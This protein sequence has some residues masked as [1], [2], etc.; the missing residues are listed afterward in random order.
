[1]AAADVRAVVLLPD[2]ERKLVPSGADAADF[3]LSVHDEAV[4]KWVFENGQMAGHGT[5]TL[6]GSEGVYLP[7]PTSRGV[8]GVLGVI[9]LSARTVD[10]EQIHLSGSI[11]RPDRL[12]VGTD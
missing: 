11:R 10:M 5:A 12:G 8:V 3:T 9:P 2:R 4:A 7:L 1:M 6:P